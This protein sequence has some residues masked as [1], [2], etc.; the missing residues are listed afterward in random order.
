[1]FNYSVCKLHTRIF[2]NGS[3]MRRSELSSKRNFKGTHTK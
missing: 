1:M 3:I 2:I